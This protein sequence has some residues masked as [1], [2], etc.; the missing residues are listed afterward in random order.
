[1]EDPWRHYLRPD[2]SFPRNGV[3]IHDGTIRV[4]FVS[5]SGK[6][7]EWRITDVHAVLMKYD[8][9]L[10]L[11][12]FRGDFYGGRMKADAEL[13]QTV[14][15]TIRQLKVD[16]RDADVARMAEGAPFI[17]HPVSGLFNAVV[18][19]TVDP[20]R[21]KQRPI[22][23]GR[24][25]ITHGNLWEFP[26]FAG[27]LNLLTLTAVTERRIDT[28]VLEFTIEED[29]IRVDKMHFL[30]HPVSLFGDGACSLTGDWIE[31]VFVPRLGKS[32]W[33]SILPII[34]TPI[35]WLSD[36]FKGALLPVVLSGSFDNPQMAVT[37]GYFLRP[38]VRTLIEEKS[39]R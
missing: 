9:I 22:A 16:V 13:P 3:H 32:D 35:Q 11:R 21:T 6:E 23:A 4:T 37:P 14:P 38:S 31:I 10:T 20:E 2:E 25:E 15:L 19:L 12:P 7:V 33:N 18:T 27:I 29:Q 1:V 36:I 28:A 5:K 34:G 30:G 39:P 8:G 17:K 26:M 24:C